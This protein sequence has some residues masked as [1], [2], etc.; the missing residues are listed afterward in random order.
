MRTIA[1]VAGIVVLLIVIWL[2]IATGVWQ[3]IVVLSGVA[4]GLVTFLLTALVLDRL[5]ARIDHERWLPVTRIALTDL[6][7]TVA[8]E[9]RSEITRG[10]VVPRVL[11]FD[12]ARVDDMFAAVHREREDITSVMQ[13]WA[14]FLAA[15]ADVRDLMAHIAVI[16]TLLDQLRDA[17]VEH[18][19]QGRALDSDEIQDLVRQYNARVQSIVDELQRLLAEASQ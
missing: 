14:A 2:D 8:D 16:A 1:T 7:H 10:H 19:K 9:E 3:D 4:A 12:S 11:N 15:S 5:M 6:L 13:S 18:E 17:A